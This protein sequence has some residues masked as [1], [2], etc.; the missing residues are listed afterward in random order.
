[1]TFYP[2]DAAIKADGFSN[3]EKTGSMGGTIRLHA[4]Q[5]SWQ[6]V[7]N[8]LTVVNRKNEQT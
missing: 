2:V 8:L 3:S 6:S 7:D 4:R 1:M 5:V